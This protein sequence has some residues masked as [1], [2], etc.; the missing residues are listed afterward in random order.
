[1]NGACSN[2]GIADPSVPVDYT[3]YLVGYINGADYGCEV[4]YQNMGQYKFVNGKLT[5]TFNQDSY[6]FVKTEGNGKWLLAESYCTDTT[7][8]FKEGGSE[9][10]FVPGNVQVTFTLTENA[11][12]SVT[13][14]Y[15]TGSASASVVP[16]LTLK[17]PTLE[18]KDMI[19]VNAMF[20]A[21]N[22]Q[23]VVQMGMI[24][25]S[26]KGLPG[27]WLLLSM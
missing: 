11:D 3:Y 10:M 7:C 16:T 13:V 27:A 22:I 18:F 21:E 26:S 25:Y 17:A 24:T 9:K 12:G 2:C 14:S 4:D 1:M 8:T 6:I 19:T 5:A 15:T 20:T 23:D